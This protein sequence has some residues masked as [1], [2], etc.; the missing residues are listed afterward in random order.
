MSGINEMDRFVAYVRVYTH[1]YIYI[2]RQ[3]VDQS[4]GGETETRSRQE[5][6]KES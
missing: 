1:I 6:K 2:H 3:R 4:V 5:G